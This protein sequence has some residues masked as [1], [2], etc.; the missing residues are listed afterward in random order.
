MRPAREVL[1]GT[2]HIGDSPVGAR[3]NHAV[4]NRAES[5]VGA[6]LLEVV[7]DF[8]EFDIIFVM[9][10]NNL[11]D[12]LNL[13]RTDADAVKVQLLL[14]DKEVPDPY[15]DNNQFEPVF[16]LIEVGCKDV[17][18]RLRDQDF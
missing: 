11:S 13:A 14:V 15:Y 1:G 2:V 6:L 7:R 5:E 9:D 16:E 12:V 3:R 8:D 4:R 18:S 17:I 10:K